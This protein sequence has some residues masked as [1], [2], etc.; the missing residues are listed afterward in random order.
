[1]NEFQAFEREVWTLFY[2]ADHK[3]YESGET[4]VMNIA[5]GALFRERTTAHEAMAMCFVPGIEA[6][7]DH[8]GN[9]I[10]RQ[11]GGEQ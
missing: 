2:A 4:Y 8:E 11:I 5:T 10:T 9:T 1:M 6:G 7:E 3:H